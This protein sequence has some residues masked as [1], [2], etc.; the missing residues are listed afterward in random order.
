MA[1]IVVSPIPPVPDIAPFVDVGLSVISRSLEK[2]AQHADNVREAPS[3]QTFAVL[4]SSTAYAAV[5]VAR[6]GQSPAFHCHF[7]QMIAVAS[8]D[9]E[10]ERATR[11]VGFTIPCADRLSASLGLP[12]VSSIGVRPGAPRSAALIDFLRGHVASVDIGWINQAQE[13]NFLGT[14][15]TAVQT[16]VGERKQKRQVT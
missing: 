13:G 14:K 6:T 7:P 10:K 3:R 2:H 1:D 12:R 5:F 15:T 8:K 16:T 9:H 11:L 4:E